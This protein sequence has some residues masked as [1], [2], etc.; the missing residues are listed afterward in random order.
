[1]KFEQNFSQQ[2]KQTQK[3]AMTQQLQQSI[4]ILQFNG[5]ELTEF[6][7]S[8][9]LENPLIDFV[10]PIYK[11]DY[12]S[13]TTSSN[14]SADDKSNYLNQIPDTHMSLFE[15]LLDQV[16]LNY[17]ETYL[18]TLVLYLL[19]F[20]DLNGFLTTNLEEAARQTGATEIQMLDALTL[21][22]QLDPAGVGA[23]NLQE[24]LMLQTERDDHAPALAY[25]VLEEKF[26]ELAQRKWEI[27]TKQFDIT[28]Q[29]VQKIFD[30]IQTLTPTPGAIFGNTS[31]LYIIPDVKVQVVD[32]QLIVT[33]NK[34][35]QPEI[36]FQQKYFDRMKQENDKEVNK[37]LKEK[38]QEF[39]WLQ[40]TLLQRG[41]TILNVAKAIIER[42]QEFFF[43][44]TR[45]INALT[46]KEISEAIGVHES[47][48]SRSVNGK[49]LETNF[50]VFELKKFFTNKLGT[51]Q[52]ENGDE[53]SADS[54]KRSLQALVDAENKAK[55]LSD[56]KLVELLK[57]QS[58][59]I[60]RRT[61]AK[62]RDQ[63]GIASSSKRKRYDH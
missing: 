60:S 5:E 20:I 35:G 37:Y 55:P 52:S 17:R 56:Q 53:L 26:T 28:L 23:R 40:K 16:H 30:Y 2:Q 14:Y 15:Y 34:K 50:G 36:H 8:K 31:E 1:M 49:Y 3:L 46:L 32:D 29:E 25:I 38:Q 59:D 19:E 61:V 42:Q 18:R 22:Q 12:S 41:D 39:E 45:P 4:Q 47:T 48:V 7:E 10:E 43:D 62:Y 33:S 21:V 51:N 63:L 44:K 57:E 24:C 54:V 6:V 27:I 11:T 9:A 58:I 13:G